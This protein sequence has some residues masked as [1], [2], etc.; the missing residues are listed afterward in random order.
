M[1]QQEEGKQVNDNNEAEI[2]EQGDIYFFYRPKKSAEEVK[3]IEDVRRFF[4]VT[5]PE[6]NKSPLY[7]LFVIGKK[8]LPEV[9]KTEARASERYWA[10][11]GGIFKDANELT[12]ELLSDEFRKGDA[13]RPVGEGKYAIIKHGNHAELAYILEMPKEPGEAQQ[14]LGIEKEASYIVSVINPR[15]PAAP[16]VTDGGSYP[17]TEE[18][19]MYPE[20]LLNEFGDNDIYIPLSKDLRFL[21]YQN[22]QVILSGAREGRDVIRNDVGIEITEEDETQQSADIFNKLKVRKERVPIKPLTEGKLE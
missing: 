6:E 18:I 22:A 21:D 10:R 2:L 7:R 1:N 5:A 16:S 20:E 12:K 17:S 11:V 4:M 13:A 8:S 14:E 9:R 3:G 19:P 15:K